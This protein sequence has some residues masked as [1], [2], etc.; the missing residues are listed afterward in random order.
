M[1]A[2]AH[3]EARTFNGEDEPGC[4]LCAGLV[5]LSETGPATPRPFCSSCGRRL[6]V[7]LVDAR[8]VALG[9]F[10]RRAARGS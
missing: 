8:G 6:P 3:L 5:G 1:A 9:A 10:P 2:A 4:E 7:V